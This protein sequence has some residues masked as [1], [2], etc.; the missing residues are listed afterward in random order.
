VMHPRLRAVLREPLVHFLVVG[1]LLFAI[2]RWRDGGAA[3]R[4]AVTAPAQPERRAIVV[5]GELRRWIEDGLRR[6]HGGQAPGAAELDEA[7]S[8]WIDEEVLYREG[9]ARGLDRDDPAVRKRIADKMAF[10]L[11]QEI[12]IPPASDAELRAW[13]ERERARFARPE[14]I[15][16]THVFVAGGG[17]EAQQRARQL[18]ARLESGE[19]P[20][21]LGDRFSGGQRYRGRKPEDLTASFG[22]EFTR[23]LDRQPIGAWQLRRSRHGLHLVRLDRVEAGSAADFAA[24][25]LDVAKEWRDQRHAEQLAARVRA[26]RETWQVVER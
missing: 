12:V 23:G 1:A 11:E 3:T 4:P 21:L 5:D 15:D 6:A 17:A 14:R 19:D 20:E 24:A 8:R 13:F 18:L 9:L 2:D 7:V 16:F 26:L 25:R 22:P 10:I